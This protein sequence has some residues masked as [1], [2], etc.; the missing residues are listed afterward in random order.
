[1]ADVETELSRL[2]KIIMSRNSSIEQVTAANNMRNKL[3]EEMIEDAFNRIEQRTD[4][5]TKLVDKLDDI[6]DGIK[7]NQLSTVMDD[8]TGVLNE[9]KQAASSGGPGG[10]S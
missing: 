1:M 9:V 7:A 6:V 3:L 4:L 5:Y 10:E 8:L 2:K